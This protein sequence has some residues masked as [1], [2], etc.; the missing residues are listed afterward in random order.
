L[1]LWNK[2]RHAARGKGI[3]NQRLAKSKWRKK[4]GGNKDRIG[5]LTELKEH[6]SRDTHTC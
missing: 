2:E 1:I 3:S 5:F 4:V 6:Q